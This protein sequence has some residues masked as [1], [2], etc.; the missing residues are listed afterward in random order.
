MQTCEVVTHKRSWKR[1]AAHVHISHIIRSLELPKRRVIEEPELHEC[2]QMRAHEG[3]KSGVL[4][5]V[6]KLNGMRNGVTSAPGTSQFATVRNLH[7]SKN[8][9]LQQ[10]CHN[11]DISQAASTTRGVYGP[12]KQVS[13][14]LLLVKFLSLAPPCLC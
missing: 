3:S 5:E 7:E 13:S 11:R 2:H 14:R 4:L 9:I 12:Q 10:Q 1:C 6:H 8:V